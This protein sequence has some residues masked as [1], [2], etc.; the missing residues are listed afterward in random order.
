MFNFLTAEWI[1]VDGR[2]PE[3][4]VLYVTCLVTRKKNIFYILPLRFD[5]HEDPVYSTAHGAVS[6][7]VSWNTTQV[8]TQINIFKLQA[9][10]IF[11]LW[12][13]KWCLA[14]CNGVPNICTEAKTDSE[15][16]PDDS[17]GARLV[18]DE[19]AATA[20]RQQQLQVPLLNKCRNF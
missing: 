3:E 8:R 19:Y 1:I 10:L 5:E 2:N 6:P 17:Y 14:T 12:W 20:C 11:S 7:R 13:R 9:F 18:D 16:L 4:I 15:Q